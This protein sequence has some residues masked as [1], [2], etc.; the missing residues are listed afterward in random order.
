[1]TTASTS[2]TL[3]GLIE[4]QRNAAART[5]ATNRIDRQQQQPLLQHA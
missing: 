5:R 1:M 4:Q 2:A 3:S